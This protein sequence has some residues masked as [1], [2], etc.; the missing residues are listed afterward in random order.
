MQQCKFDPPK[1]S[2]SWQEA[3]GGEL[4]LYLEV[5]LPAPKKYVQRLK[6]EGELANLN[7]TIPHPLKV[8]PG[9]RYEGPSRIDAILLS[10]KTGV[11]VLFEA[12]VLSDVSYRTTW[13]SR[14]SP[15]RGGGRC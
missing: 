10:K 13:D 2:S 6:G 15:A 14:S 11:A 8:K 3:L 9:T 1:G 7:P 12:K 5:A 4:R